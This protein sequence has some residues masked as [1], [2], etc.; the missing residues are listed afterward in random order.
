MADHST[1]SA[2]DVDLHNYIIIY[3]KERLPNYLLKISVIMTLSL[4]PLPPSPPPLLASWQ[5]QL[6]VIPGLEDSGRYTCI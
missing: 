6:I 4:G 1:E 5:R 2:Y 3:I